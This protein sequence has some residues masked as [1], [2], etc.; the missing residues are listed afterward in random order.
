MFSVENSVVKSLALSQV[1]VLAMKLQMPLLPLNA[2]KRTETLR[3]FSQKMHGANVACLEAACGYGKSSLLAQHLNHKRQEKHNVAWLTLDPKENDPKRFL[4]YLVSAISHS[5]SALMHQSLSAI[6]DG[7]S[8]ADIFNSMMHELQTAEDDLFIA[9]DDVHH[10]ENLDVLNYLQSL[11]QFLPSNVHLYFTSRKKFPINLSQQQASGQV[12]VFSENDLALSFSETREWLEK[13]LKQEITLEQHKQAYDLTQGWLD[14]LNVLLQYFSEHQNFHIEAGSF[15]LNSYFEQQWRSELTQDEFVC[16]CRLAVLGQASA[17]YLYGVFETSDLKHKKNANLFY[18]NSAEINNADLLNELSASH[19]LIMKQV[20]NQ[21][22]YSLHPMLSLYLHS[23]FQLS[24]LKDVYCQASLWL[25]KQGKIMPSVEMA[26]KS[27]DK[28]LAAEFLQVMAEN[29]LEEQDLAQL[30]QWKQQLPDDVICT[31]PRLIIIFSWTLALALQ[32]DDAERLM[33]RMD[34]IAIAHDEFKNDEVSGQLFSIRAYI[35]R[36]RGNLDNAQQLCLQAINKLSKETYMARCLTYMNLTNICMTQDK[37]VEARKYN[38]L[39]F[40]AS[41]A[42]GSIHLEMLV[43]HE[44]A[45]IEQTK[46]NLFL[47]L[48]LINEGLL[49]AERLRYKHKAAAYGRLLI[50]KGYISWLQNDVTQATEHLENGIEV[51]IA[52]RDTYFSMGSIVLSNIARQRHDG[53]KA[54]DYLAAVEAQL[55][56]WAVPG[57]VFQP[58]LSAMRSNLLID[59]GRLESAQSNLK[60]LAALGQQNPYALSPEHYPALRG[61]V[62]VFFVRAKSINGH[63]KEALKL[64]DEKIPSKI[65]NQQ[66]FALTFVYLMRALLRFQLGNEDEALQDFKKAVTLA[67]DDQCLMPFIEYSS[68]MSALYSRLPQALK[69][70]PFVQLI[71]QNIEVVEDETHNQAFA[72]AKSVISQ[73]EFAVLELIAQGLSNQ[74]IAEKLFI[75]LHTVKTHARRINAKL[76]VKNRTQAIIRAKEIGLIA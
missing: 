62:E 72:Q 74:G 71:L 33:A 28:L 18:G 5:N 24:V 44:L 9:L 1:R 75:S 40:E 53:E 54:F 51:A 37:L 57:V 76:N 61:M 15:L 7:L 60:E 27:G 58:W 43:V 19:R 36:N 14:G 32:L 2:I 12:V 49:L 30:L 31:S 10:L 66:G 34:S 56:R 8:E 6:D 41:R 39:A 65:N 45:R 63:H 59:Q 3:H 42:S 64:L 20:D 48:K 47:S 17:D 50:Y 26:L 68:G 16:A 67:Q 13:N 35:A 22:R 73:R 4:T 38:R 70:T 52:C 25:H 21:V 69:Q 11:I 46:G 55:Q 23:L 29:I